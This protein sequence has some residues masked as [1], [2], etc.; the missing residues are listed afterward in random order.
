MPHSFFSIILPIQNFWYYSPPHPFL[1]QCKNGIVPKVCFIEI[2][3]QI[4]RKNADF[5]K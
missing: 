3:R 2:L 1:L 5:K 4:H